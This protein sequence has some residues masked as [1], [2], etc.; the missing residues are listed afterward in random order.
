MF[1]YTITAILLN[2]IIHSSQQ[3]QQEQTS[4][5]YFLPGGQKHLLIGLFE[6]CSHKPPQNQTRLNYE[7]MI[8]LRTTKQIFEPSNQ[9]ILNDLILRRFFIYNQIKDKGFTISDI[10]LVTFEVCTPNDLANI[11]MQLHLNN[12]YNIRKNSKGELPTFHDNPIQGWENKSRIL[13]MVVYTNHQM[14]RR[15]SHYLTEDIV[16]Y[17]IFS[18]WTLDELVPSHIPNFAGHFILFEEQS[19]MEADYLVKEILNN[20]NISYLTVINLQQNLSIMQRKNFESFLQV[21]NSSE[22]CFDFD[23]IDEATT[24]ETRRDQIISTLLEINNVNKQKIIML[25]GNTDEQKVFLNK[26]ISMGLD[27]ATWFLRDVDQNGIENFPPTTSIYTYIFIDYLLPNI[28]Q[29]ASQ[30]SIFNLTINSATRLLST[31]E[32]DLIT[33]RTYLTT[34][35]LLSQYHRITIQMPLSK[36]WTNFRKLFTQEMRSSEGSMATFKKIALHKG[37]P[38]LFFDTSSLKNN[39][40]PNCPEFICPKGWIPIFGHKPTQFTPWKYSQGWTCEKCP[41]GTYK[42]NTGHGVCSMCP[43]YTFSAND[44]S[45]CIDPYIPQYLWFELISVK[46]FLSFNTVCLLTCIFIM[47]VFFIYRTTPVVVTSDYTLSQIHLTSFLLN[48]ASLPF[49]YLGIPQELTCTLKPILL[50]ATSGVSLSI[51][52]MKSH[53]MLKAY[54]SKIKISKK[55][56]VKSVRMQAMA[57]IFLALLGQAIN[58]VANVAV[59]APEIIKDRHN[60]FDE[61]GSEVYHKVIYC[62]TSA[63]LHVQIVY[64]IALQLVALV[65][66]FQG[67]KLP[68]VLN[69]S[70]SIV[71]ATFTACIIYATMFPIYFF[72]KSSLDGIKVHWFCLLLSNFSFMVIFYMSKINIILF[73]PDQNTKVYYRVKMMV[74]AKHRANRTIINRSRNQFLKMRKVKNMK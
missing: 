24:N 6:T 43:E 34:T 68:R 8:A 9:I 26:A 40:W 63:H 20:H 25:F 33:L 42:G 64:F 29:V 66:A 47:T 32:S 10:H 60:F 70:L 23:V 49:V 61:K 62:N 28:E 13:A 27:N 14:L 69:E 22:K 71:Y 54:K 74:N 50:S 15:F 53:K 30:T 2:L 41:I 19:L 73:H 57:I 67:R 36:T 38:A 12:E 4:N 39:G 52:V 46:L 16:Q 37:R 56:R 35:R 45:R 44:R 65:R 72:Q 17:D 59:G 48:F 1:A 58:Y 5:G 21:F 51:V 7:A 55:A 31:Q 11:S 3:H 18:V